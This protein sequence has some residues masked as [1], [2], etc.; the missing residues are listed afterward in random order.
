MCLVRYAPAVPRR[1]GA[2]SFEDFLDVVDAM[3]VLERVTLQGLGEPLLSPHLEAMIEH[4]VARGA[5]VG[6]NTNAVL[7][8]RGRATRLVDA[9]L[10]WLHV[11]L[12]G[13]TAATYEDVRHGT[14]L[15]PR[16]GQFERVVANL[17][18]LVEVRRARGLDHPR[19][20]VV[21]VA[22]RRNVEELADLVEL[23]AGIG[24]DE[25]WVQNLSHDFSDTDGGG[26]YAA[27]REYVREEALLG[28]EPPAFGRA[29]RA[30]AR[31]GLKLRLPAGRG[32][33]APRRPAG[34]PGCGWPWHGAYVTHRGD[35]QPCCMVMG[36]D[37]ARMGSL[38]ESSFEEIWAGEAYRGFRERLLGDAPPAVCRG[39]SEYRGLF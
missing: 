28:D 3:P 1:E 39:C 6:F 7:L 12:D 37:R 38:R 11:S 34:E 8:D 17:R 19:I 29:R 10:S 22:M 36:S 9:G 31:H 27:M 20:L 23:A 4:V 33:P 26:P 25:V 24:V 15:E 5:R 13:A 18:G 35:I 16:P 21:F 14:S 30:A 32:T 2:L